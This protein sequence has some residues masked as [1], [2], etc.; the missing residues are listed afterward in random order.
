MELSKKAMEL[1]NSLEALPDSDEKSK[2]QSMA[3]DFYY[4]IR[5]VELL[6]V[7][8]DCGY[9]IP[10]TRGAHSHGQPVWVR[11]WEDCIRAAQSPGVGRP[12]IPHRTG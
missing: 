1:W 11:Y 2:I 8:K 7:A 4:A 9:A 6:D 10:E 5:Y 12:V 3:S